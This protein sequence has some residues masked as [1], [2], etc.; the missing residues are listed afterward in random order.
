MEKE[1][2]KEID[3]EL[4][5]TEKR[6]LAGEIKT[7]S[8]AE[9]K[10]RQKEKRK[11]LRNMSQALKAKSEMS[12]YNK[13]KAISAN[14]QTVSLTGFTFLADR[15][16]DDCEECLVVERDGQLS[17]GCWDIG[18]RRTEDGE[19]GVFHQS[20][21][22]VLNVSDVLAWLPIEKCSIDIKQICWNPE[23]HLIGSTAYGFTVYAKDSDPCLIVE[24]TG[25]N[26][27]TILFNMD[28]RTGSCLAVNKDDKEEISCIKGGLKAWCEDNKERL[29]EDYHSGNYS[30]LP[31]WV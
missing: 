14:Y 29:I 18:T 4:I 24:Y 17:A 5:N 26:D 10:E 1:R 3:E 7:T 2:K 30:V 15:L 21:G 8:L 27:G 28:V 6:I 22:G 11:Q 9:F 31:E 19:P 12:D 16:P 25:G 23:Y 20:R 13:V